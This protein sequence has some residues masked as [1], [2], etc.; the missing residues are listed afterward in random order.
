MILCHGETLIDFIPTSA[1]DGSLAYRP[2]NGGSPHNVA[3]ALGRLDVPVGFVGGISTDFFGDALAKG[4]AASGV[5]MRYVTRL[6]RPT[7]L[8]FVS[9]DGEEA[10]YAF[11][12]TEAA[13]R[14]WR[15]D[16]MPA[17]G[18]EVKALHFGAISLLRE[19]AADAFAGL[20]RREAGRRLISFD[21]NIRPGLVRDQRAYRARL[22]EF[23]RRAHV[24]KVSQADLDWIAPGA[25]AA[26]L[27]RQ[28][29][30]AEARLVLWTRGADGATVFARGATVTRPAIPVAVVDTVG[31]GDAFMAGF[32]AV[33]HDNGWLE[34]GAVT[35]NLGDAPIRAA[36]DF[37]LAVA[38]ITV[39]R[40]GADPPTRAELAA[41]LKK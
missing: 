8:A 31:A 3:L 20:M 38:A 40:I 36:L 17:I 2:A 15:L 26:E 21:P 28:W 9:L 35:G 19:P 23:F 14:H 18:A 11:Y 16:D 12:D 6:E 29:L 34:G 32:L 30:A 41:F 7:T 1:G 13:D 39:S 37:A 33:A 10:R 22:D 27:A 25:D 5:D 24:I 4:L